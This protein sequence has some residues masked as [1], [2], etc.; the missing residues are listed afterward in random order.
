MPTSHRCAHGWGGVSWVKDNLCSRTNVATRD[1]GTS[2][3]TWLRN[4]VEFK[5]NVT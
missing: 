1:E 5:F 4:A 3:V 2:Q